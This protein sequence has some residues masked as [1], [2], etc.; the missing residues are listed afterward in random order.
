[1]KKILF[2]SFI[3]LLG[4]GY[5]F[6]VFTDKKVYVKPVV[7]VIKV[8]TSKRPYPEYTRYPILLEK[9]LTNQIVEELNKRGATV[10]KEFQES[11]ILECTIYDYRQEALRYTDND[12]VKEERLRLYVK[13]KYFSPQ[14]E[15]I[16]EKD[17][18]GQTTYFLSGP[19]AKSEAQAWED[20]VEDTA[21]RIVESI[22]QDW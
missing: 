14:K 12:E 10:F 20:L 15:L 11:N 2:V 16:K 8:S 4:C 13:V 5:T 19:Y 21:Q 6:G 3:F 1:M 7:N 17:I 22:L 9:L 18:V